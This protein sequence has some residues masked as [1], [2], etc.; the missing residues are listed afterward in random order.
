MTPFAVAESRV[1]ECIGVRPCGH[2]G[3]VARGTKTCRARDEHDGSVIWR[4]L[5]IGAL[6][7]LQG[8]TIRPHGEER[9]EVCFPGVAQYGAQRS[10]APQTRDRSTRRPIIVAAPGSTSGN[11][12][13]T[14]EAIGSPNP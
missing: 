12:T 5:R 7:V 3:F 2:G 1:R 4:A 10:A 11:V 6:C 9:S 13:Q 14:Y 8:D